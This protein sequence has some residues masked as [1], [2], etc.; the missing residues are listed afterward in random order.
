VTLDLLVPGG[1]RL[2]PG[3]AL[4]RFLEA[5]KARTATMVRTNRMT[6]PG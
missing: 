5:V 4:P 6:P 1:W 2:Q 3:E